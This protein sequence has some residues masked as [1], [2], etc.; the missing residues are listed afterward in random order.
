MY[1]VGEED[2]PLTSHWPSVHDIISILARGFRRIT[3]GY[4]SNEEEYLTT[5]VKAQRLP[6]VRAL[7][8]SIIEKHVQ[9]R[10]KT[11]EEG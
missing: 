11:G 7:L 4:D 10:S 9:R 5:P 3:L 1:C 6:R 8:G 2:H